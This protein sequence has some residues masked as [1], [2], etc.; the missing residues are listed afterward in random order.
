[1]S[2][3]PLTKRQSPAGFRG[4]RYPIL[5]PDQPT[6]DIDTAVTRL[7]EEYELFSEICLVVRVLARDAHSLF[8]IHYTNICAR[9]F[10][11]II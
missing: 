9:V 1:M 2:L 10:M 3:K 7:V 6:E 11:P 5:F 8:H 4:Q